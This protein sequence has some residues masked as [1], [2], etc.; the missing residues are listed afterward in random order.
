MSCVCVVTKLRDVLSGFRP[1]NNET[2]TPTLRKSRSPPTQL[3]GKDKLSKNEIW[4]RKKNVYTPTSLC[5]RIMCFF[6]LFVHGMVDVRPLLFGNN[7]WL[8]ETFKYNPCITMLPFPILPLIYIVFSHR[9]LVDSLW[10]RPLAAPEPLKWTVV[11]RTHAGRNILATSVLNCGLR[12]C[13]VSAQK[14]C[15]VFVI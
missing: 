3:S 10:F 8:S 2:G 11:Q 7:T 12:A 4:I 14:V 5:V 9:R 13:C 1:Q 15:G 6:Y